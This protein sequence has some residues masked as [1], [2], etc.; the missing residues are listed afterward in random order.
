MSYN[1]D[2][3]FQI[4]CWLWG[5]F[6][7]VVSLGFVVVVVGGGVVV[8]VVVVVVGWLGGGCL[9]DWLGGGGYL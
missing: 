5:L 6:G 2:D 9:V 7:V 3:T 4:C 1:D 8:V